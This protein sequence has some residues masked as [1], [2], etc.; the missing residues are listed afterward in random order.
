MLHITTYRE[1][2]RGAVV[3]TASDGSNELAPEVAGAHIVAAL[4][5][6]VVLGVEVE[7]RHCVGVDTE[8]QHVHVLVAAGRLTAIPYAKVLLLPPVEARYPGKSDRVV[9]GVEDLGEEGEK[10]KQR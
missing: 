9:G 2:R 4:D 7:A 1:G 6:E 10:D 8:L 3:L 5:R